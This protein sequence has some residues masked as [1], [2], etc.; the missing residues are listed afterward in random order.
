MVRLRTIRRSRRTPKLLALSQS[1]RG[2]LS[3]LLAVSKGYGVNTLIQQS[4]IGLYRILR[5]RSCFAQ[6]DSGC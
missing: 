6:D 4:R 3:V 1:L 2:I 5:L